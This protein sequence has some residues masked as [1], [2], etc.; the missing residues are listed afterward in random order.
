MMFRC[1]FFFVFGI[2]IQ[3]SHG[4][5]F[6][7]TKDGKLCL[8]ANLELRFSVTYEDLDN[9]TQTAVFALADDANSTKSTCDAKHSMLMLNFGEGHAFS[10]SFSKIEEGY[11][12]D[13]VTF[14]YNLGDPV[15]FPNSK[16]KEPT[17]AT[18]FPDIKNIGM[19]TCY[20]CKSE[21]LI[22]S[23]DVNITLWDVQMQAFI[24]DG[25]KS[26]EISS[27]PADQP[28][29]STTAA[30][31]TT[32]TAAPNATTTTVTTTLAPNTTTLAPNTTTLAPNTTTLAPNTTTLA[33]NTTTLAPN[34]T[35]L[36]PNTTTMP[37]PTTTP[38]P[39][40]PVPSTGNY[41]IGT[42]NGTVCLLANFGLRIGIKG[43]EMNLDPNMANVSGSCGVNSSEL[44]LASKKMT[45]RF[46]FTNDT[47]KFRLHDLNISV[48]TSS[49]HFSVE[50]S[51]LNLWEASIGSSYMCNKEQTFNITDTLSIHTFSLHVQPFGVNKGVFSTAEEC[52]AD[53]ESFL[54]PIAVGVALLVLILIVLL[55]YFI[56][57]RRSMATGYQSF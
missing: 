18:G 13:V 3:L 26:S 38:V 24:S 55:A 56:G 23:G 31:N 39:T 32:T 1:L 16:S 28:I 9:Q 11:E 20:S 19:D 25:N 35:T 54:V 45:I 49:G 46:T 22:E 5:E 43:E 6:N 53:G 33:P 48:S 47:K 44:T 40:L 50:N 10:M 2:V 36:A 51:S 37:V 21:D 17:V 27:C 12:A 57:R 8:Y 7:V 52:L 29:S 4:I 30:P 15:H 41:S 42:E 34:T 14:T